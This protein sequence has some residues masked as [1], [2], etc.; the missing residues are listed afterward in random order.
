MSLRKNIG[1]SK[2]LFLTFLLLSVTS[3]TIREANYCKMS[4]CIV[5]N[6]VKE[7]ARPREL[8]LSS[9]GGAMMD[10]IQEVFL[11]FL[12]FRALNIDEARVL[13]VEMMEEF[14]YRINHHEEIR[15][16]L[17]NFP[18]EEKN[19][20]LSIGFEDSDRR[21]TRDGHVAMVFIGNNH[22]VYYDAYDSDEGFYTLC[23][24]SYE[25]A[26]RIVQEQCTLSA[27]TE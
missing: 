12:S 13:Y 15:P 20:E 4:D 8:M 10:D 21:I 14:L 18:F 16:Y 9:S 26:R 5:S 6:Y 1:M 11:S 25:E 19:F 22:T 23:K 7:F 24:E 27:S 2:V 17:H 3:C